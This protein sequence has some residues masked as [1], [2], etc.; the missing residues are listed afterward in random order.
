M[1]SVYETGGRPGL[2]GTLYLSPDIWLASSEGMEFLCAISALAMNS[3]WENLVSSM[4]SP[5]QGN[6]YVV[7]FVT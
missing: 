3:S 5:T 1:G 7:T 6:T 2:G 4:T